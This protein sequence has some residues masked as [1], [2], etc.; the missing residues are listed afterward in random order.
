MRAPA[1]VRAPQVDQALGQ[2]AGEQ[3]LHGVEG[4]GVATGDEIVQPRLRWIEQIERQLIL[5]RHVSGS[6]AKMRENGSQRGAAF[7]RFTT[8]RAFASCAV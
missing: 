7:V 4:L 3:A 8:M 1:S 2:R 6:G 5:E